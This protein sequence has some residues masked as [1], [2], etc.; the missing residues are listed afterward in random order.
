MV[1][2]NNDITNFTT[3][4]TRR[5]IHRTRRSLCKTGEV[6][7][8]LIIF[9]GVNDM[10]VTRFIHTPQSTV[11]VA[12]RSAVSERVVFPEPPSTAVHQLILNLNRPVTAEFP[13][14]VVSPH[15]SSSGRVVF[16]VLFLSAALLNIISVVDIMAQRRKV[17]SLLTSKHTCV[18]HPQSAT[19]TH[20]NDRRSQDERRSRTDV[21]HISLDVLRLLIPTYLQQTS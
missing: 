3:T 17:I 9:C 11:H 16:S 8:L 7:A 1:P 10:V 20:N 18:V 15:A 6:V 12:V 14:H 21:D 13:R 5:G 2:Q 19:R 4:R